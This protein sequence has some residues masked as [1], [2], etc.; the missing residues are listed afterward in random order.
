[1]INNGLQNN[2]M[3]LLSVETIRGILFGCN[4]RYMTS[5]N[6]SDTLGKSPFT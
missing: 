3:L 6:G 5:V 2:G 4:D 1:M